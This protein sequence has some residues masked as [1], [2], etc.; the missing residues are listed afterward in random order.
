MKNQYFGDEHDF[1]KYLLL[2]SFMNGSQ[3]PLLVAWYLT[4]NEKEESENKN[5]GNKRAYLKKK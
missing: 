3:I 4:P 2:R 1:K 5:D